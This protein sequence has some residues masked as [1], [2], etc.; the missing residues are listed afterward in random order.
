MT[1]SDDRLEARLRAGGDVPLAP[2][3]A[4]EDDL[5]ELIAGR[6]GYRGRRF[7]LA[8]SSPR[9]AWIVGLAL[10]AVALA[11]AAILAGQRLSRPSAGE[12]AERSRALYVSQTPIRVEVDGFEVTTDGHGTW[13]VEPPVS[14][15]EG[16][17]SAGYVVWSAS[18]PGGV[19]DE[20]HEE[21]LPLEREGAAPVPV[22]S[23]LFWSTD[24]RPAPR[25]RRGTPGSLACAE[26]ADVGA[27]EVAGR[28]ARPIRCVERSLDLWLD[29][30]TLLVLRIEAGDRTPGWDPGAGLT[31]D[32]VE[33]P[34]TVDPARFAL[35]APPGARVPGRPARIAVGE[36]LPAW[37]GT[38]LDG[39]AVGSGR[40]GG[41]PTVLALW[42]S[43]C[44]P[45]LDPAMDAFESLVDRPDVRLVT[46]AIADD[47][48]TVAETPAVR[49]RGL[50]VVIDD[51]AIQDAFGVDAV[52]VV[53]LVDADGV[54]R[55]LAA[56]P[57]A[58]EVLGRAVDSLL[59]GREPELPTIPAPGG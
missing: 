42:S 58:P 33:L 16:E 11:T 53:V 6:A 2:R 49:D 18:E 10:L 51:G 38:T 32:A 5:Y 48:A 25:T 9:L 37:S 50:P 43:W 36:P 41:T 19:W 29:A 30:E 34:A 27:D 40:I 12:L 8:G 7:V 28:G 55:A 54:V 23:E 47:P 22:S 21:W 26:W 57:V 13:R 52:P 35:E 20:T 31:A 45:C 24:T 1:M 14:V 39:E 15:L 59:A 4:F 46:I 44:P 3:R 17:R 56:G